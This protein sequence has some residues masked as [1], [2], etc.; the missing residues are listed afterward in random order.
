MVPTCVPFAEGKLK[1]RAVARL[2]DAPQP[3]PT[4][5]G[6]L[7]SPRIRSGLCSRYSQ[8]VWACVPTLLMKKNRSAA[9]NT[10]IPKLS[11]RRWKRRLLIGLGVF[12]AVILVMMGALYAFMK[13]SVLPLTDGEKLGDGMV[14]TVVTGYFGPVAIGA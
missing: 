13:Y 11:A 8:L 14:T 5:S 10:A 4:I 2:C 1:T 3:S 6:R 12:A 7:R 9:M